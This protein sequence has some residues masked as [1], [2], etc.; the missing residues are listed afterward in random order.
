MAR[1]ILQQSFRVAIYARVSTANNGQ[2][3]SLQTRE[4]KEYCE[5]RGWQLAG[6]YVD[7]GIS[8][9]KENVQSWIASWRMPTGDASMLSWSGNSIVSPD[10]SPTFCVP[11]KRSVR[12]VWSLFHFLSNSTHRPR[13]A[14]LCSPFW[15]L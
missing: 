13:P 5:R 7:I 2:D 8:G 6:E 1:G 14:S 15:A 3:P 10:L 11:W 9:A 4:I 12:S